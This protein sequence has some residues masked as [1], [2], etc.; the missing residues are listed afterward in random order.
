MDCSGR[1]PQTRRAL[2]GNSLVDQKPHLVDATQR[3]A[4]E[5]GDDAVKCC[6]NGLKL[7]LADAQLD[8]GLAV[9]DVDVA[10]SIN[11]GLGEKA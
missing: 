6:P 2:G 10:A 3:S 9:E 8:H 4:G 7:A 1:R 5:A 11:E